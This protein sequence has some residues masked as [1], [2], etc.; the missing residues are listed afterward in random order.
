[1]AGSGRAA[2][3]R[4]TTKWL[5]SWT[6]T[7]GNGSGQIS[8]TC[9]PRWW[10]AGPPPNSSQGASSGGLPGDPP[11]PWRALRPVPGRRTG[12]KNTATRLVPGRCG[13]GR[14]GLPPDRPAGPVPAT[15]A[16][17]IPRAGGAL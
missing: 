10:V 15:A 9:L 5:H 6:V 16:T 11:R 12:H 8:S 7:A 13:E 3:R 17:L 14:I 4:R 2:R 1:M